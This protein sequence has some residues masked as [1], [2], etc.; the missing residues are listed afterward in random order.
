MTLA[1]VNEKSRHAMTPVDPCV[2]WEK[3][4][5]EM[6]LGVVHDMVCKKNTHA[7]TLAMVCEKSMHAMTLV[8]VHGK[9]RHT[10]TLVDP[11]V[12]CGKN[13][14]AMT[15]VDPCVVVVVLGTAVPKK[16]R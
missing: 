12:V 16:V 5:H 7:M 6:T 4:T 2:V 3:N 1:V 14:H 11:C 10:I 15:L 8:V 13:T 9:S